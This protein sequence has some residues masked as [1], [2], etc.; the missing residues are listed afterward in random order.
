MVSRGLRDEEIGR[1]IEFDGDDSEV[2][3]LSDDD[4]DDTS[5][6]GPLIED[7]E[8]EEH[9]SDDSDDSSEEEVPLATIA[10]RQTSSRR[11]YFKHQDHFA[12]Y[13]PGQYV[14]PLAAS[15]G[16]VLGKP[17]EYFLKYIPDDLYEKFSSY[18]NQTY[19]LKK[20]HNL[21]TTAEEMKIKLQI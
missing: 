8:D 17:I 11:L 19:L 7:L 10:A 9:V 4:A 21:N 14:Q 18:S 6:P 15:Q 20:G 12:P 13:P 5:A 16:S 2:E 3:G 1:I